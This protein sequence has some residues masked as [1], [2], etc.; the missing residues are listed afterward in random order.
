[1]PAGVRASGVAAHVP[2]PEQTCQPTMG[3][4]VTALSAV[5]PQLNGGDTPSDV[6]SVWQWRAAAGSRA[7]RPLAARPKAPRSR[8]ERDPAWAGLSLFLR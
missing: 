1:V 4:V 6:S 2:M 8:P 5:S 3:I 7:E